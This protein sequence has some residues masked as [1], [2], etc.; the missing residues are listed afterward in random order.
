MSWIQGGDGPPGKVWVEQENALRE[1]YN[2]MIRVAYSNVRNKSDAHDVVQEAWVKILSRQESL[3]EE[4]KLMAWAKTITRNVA[5]NVNKVAGRM[6]PCEVWETGQRN[7][8]SS[9]A[10]LMLEISE[11]LGALD[12]TTRTLILYKFY[13]GFKDREIAD[14][15]N[16]PVGTVKARIH[17]TRER[18]KDGLAYP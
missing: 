2:Q 12:P 13:Y 6:Q 7:A 1:L 15:L 9:E 4:S 5:V 17:R 8:G 14:A 11:L 10:E 18:L 3:R 16:M